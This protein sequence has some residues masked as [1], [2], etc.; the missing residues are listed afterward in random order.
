MNLQK[1]LEFESESSG[2]PAKIGYEENQQGGDM[3][4]KGHA[5]TL[6]N[7]SVAELSRLISSRKALQHWWTTVPRHK[8]QKK[9][10]RQTWTARATRFISA[11]WH[12]RG[13]V[14]PPEASCKLEAMPRTPL[15][16]QCTKCVTASHPQTSCLHVAMKHKPAPA[17]AAA[18]QQII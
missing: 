12:F 1:Y 8:R 5:S 14:L 4:Y 2:G 18:A 3:E 11:Q 10:H 7:C 16:Y 15:E 17:L 9:N 13:R 6:T